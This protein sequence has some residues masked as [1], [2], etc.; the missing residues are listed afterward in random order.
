MAVWTGCT[1]WLMGLLTWA[2]KRPSKSSSLKYRSG[3][4]SPVFSFCFV[5]GSRQCLTPPDGLAIGFC[6]HWGGR[7]HSRAFYCVSPSLLN[8]TVIR[9]CRHEGPQTSTGAIL[10][11]QTWPKIHRHEWKNSFQNQTFRHDSTRCGAVEMA[12]IDN[13][14]GKEAF[15]WARVRLQS[16]K[17]FH[18]TFYF[19]FSKH[20]IFAWVISL[21]RHAFVWLILLCVWLNT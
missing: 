11:S 14:A 3:K 10:I 1:G 16:L 19:W 5:V 17:S 18:Y 7:G 20:I 12:L 2:T 4:Q 9:L 6:G 21:S 15:C 13:Y 8:W